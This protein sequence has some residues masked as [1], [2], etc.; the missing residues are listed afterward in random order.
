RL[1]T[2]WYLLSSMA[3]V[4]II[5]ALLAP[6]LQARSEYTSLAALLVFGSF[7]LL[8]VALLGMGLFATFWSMRE[9]LW[10]FRGQ[11]IV[12]ITAH[13]IRLQTANLWFSPP[14]VFLAEHIRAMRQAPQVFRPAE[15]LAWLRQPGRWGALA[16]D[17]GA[18]T[19]R[20]G[21]S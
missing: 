5:G 16:F 4:I 8:F 18:A 14:R 21:N 1:I 10:Q 12:S 2:M 15:R 3:W 19:Y 11:E 9:L 17:Y 6:L 13:D 20:F 7:M